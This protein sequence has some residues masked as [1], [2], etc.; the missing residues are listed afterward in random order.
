MFYGNILWYT[1]A[2]KGVVAKLQRLAC[3][4][5]TGVM[6]STSTAAL[7]VLLSLDPID[8]QVDRELCAIGLFKECHWKAL[9]RWDMRVS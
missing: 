3:L 9:K 7:E 6:T 1:S 2:E 8:L 5:V 4:S